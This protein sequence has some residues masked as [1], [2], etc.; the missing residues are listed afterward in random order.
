MAVMDD[1]A[2]LHELEAYLAAAGQPAADRPQHDRLMRR[3]L[4][5]LKDRAKTFPELI[6]KAHFS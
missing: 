6:E 5:C 1:A 2:L 4:Y 3:A